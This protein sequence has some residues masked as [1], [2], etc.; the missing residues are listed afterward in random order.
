LPLDGGDLTLALN[1]LAGH[2]DDGG[3]AVVV[4]IHGRPRPLAA[5]IEEELYRITKEALTNSLRHANASV[6]GID[7]TFE[8]AAVRLDDHF[9]TP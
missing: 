9:T 2:P 1:R 5:K 6:I 8:L 3:P 4:H 7:L